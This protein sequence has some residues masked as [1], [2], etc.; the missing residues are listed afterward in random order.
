MK[1]KN[2][3]S[4]QLRKH[5]ATDKVEI[6]TEN[7]SENFPE[8]LLNDRRSCDNTLQVR[9]GNVKTVALLDSGASIG[10]VSHSLLNKIQ[11]KL[12][13]YQK[14]DVTIIYGVGNVVQDVS[15]HVQFNFHIGQNQ[16]TNSFY[17][18]QNNY[19]LI[20]GMDFLVKNK[21]IL[22]YEN[23]TV[24]LNGTTFDLSAP[25]RRSTLVKSKQAQLI[26]A[27]TS[28]DIP[29]GFTRP[30]ESTCMLLEP[31][32][33]LT[34]V[35]PGLEVP[36]AVVSSQSTTCRVTN[37]TDT[38]ISIPAGCVV[39]LARNIVL[40]SVTE[41]ID[42]FQP[43]TDNIQVNSAEQAHDEGQSPDYDFN[44]IMPFPVS[45]PEDDLNFNINNPKLSAEEIAELI[46][47][48]VKNKQAFQN[49]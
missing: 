9:I 45:D 6:N 30:V 31:V 14:P 2:Q 7:N 16:F 43:V 3:C 33:S 32:M 1:L 8:V 11:P 22:D 23:S 41:I 35:A 21:G 37:P 34:R 25:P 26:D 27:F 17:A 12:L 20:L 18:I 46:A 48:L 10:C 4:V 39:A 40:G 28:M 36:L 42:F 38:P 19:P 47:F 15:S 49:P 13:E 24:K 5:Q 29:V 44:K